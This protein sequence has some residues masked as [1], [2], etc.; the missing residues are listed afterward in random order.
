MSVLVFDIGG[1][2]T[3]IGLSKNGKTLD[4]TK[5]IAT[6]D[7]PEQALAQMTEVMKVLAPKGVTAIA[8]GIRGI[9]RE[10]KIGIDHD[11]I[12][13]NWVNISIVD[14]FTE[15]FSVPTYLE[16]DTALAGL[17]EATFGAG[18]GIDLLVYHSIS[19]GVGGVKLVSGHIDAASVGL[20]LGTRCSILII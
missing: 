12:L 13:R 4:A 14:H 9:L 16:N 15:L 18:Q 1:T 6:S 17:G 10:D 20:N 7:N 19:T 8:G 2:K 5:T 11:D 3:R